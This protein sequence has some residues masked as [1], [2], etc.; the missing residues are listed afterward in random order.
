[1]V[2]KLYTMDEAA[3]ILRRGKR[4][5]AQFLAKTPTDEAGIPYFTTNGNRKLFSERDLERIV[6]AEREELRCR[7]NSSRR[8]RGSR[9]TTTPEFRT[10]DE[11]WAEAH[12]LLGP[13]LQKE[14]V[15]QGSPRARV[16]PL[17]PPRKDRDPPRST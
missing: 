11:L 7:L 3:E 12:R 4:K 8:G 10:S 5:L 16:V 15:K 13:R 17:P 1:M 9:R 14:L 2:V 6:A